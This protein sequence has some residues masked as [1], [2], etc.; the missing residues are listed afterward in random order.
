MCMPF[1]T[2][3]R[4]VN[5]CESGT[6]GRLFGLDVSINWPSNRNQNLIRGRQLSW[7]YFVRKV[8]NNLCLPFFASY[9]RFLPVTFV[10]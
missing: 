9:A 7:I 2:Y 8:L 1:R 4:D 10:E 5:P 6:K 3:R